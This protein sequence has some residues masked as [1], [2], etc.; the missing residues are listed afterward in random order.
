MFRISNISKETILTR[1]KTWGRKSSLAIIDQGIFS[2]A[3]F[4][5]A[6]LLA[7]WLLPNDYGAF[8]ISFSILMIFYQIYVS[9]LLDPITVLAPLQNLG[10]LKDYLA[11]QLKSHFIITILS[12]VILIVVAMFW[13][14]G[15]RIIQEMVVTIG[16]VLPVLLLPWYFRRVFY[17]LGDPGK[18]LIGSFFYALTL[19]VLTFIAYKI[20][21]L[22]SQSGILIM[23]GASILC[24]VYFLIAFRFWNFNWLSGIF[25][26]FLSQNWKIGKWL[27][28]SS[29][30]I[31]FAS[32]IQIWIANT[33]FGLASSATLRAFQ[34]LTQPM[35]LIITALTTLSIP[36]LT[37]DFSNNNFYSYHRKIIFLGLSLLFLALV[38]EIFLFTFHL[39]IE[40]FIYAGKFSK[41]TYLLPIWGIIPIILAYTSG[42]QAGFQAIK[43]PQALL[44][45]SIIWSVGSAILGIWLSLQLGLIGLVWS[46]VLG[47]LLFAI[48]L[49]LLYV[50]WIYIPY[51]KNKILENE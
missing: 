40:F 29:F 28:F 47:Y 5:L 39:Q 48:V 12:G 26:T 6:V 21:K 9:F 32:Q 15:N 49:S 14:R 37:I 17:I 7:R 16:S 3:N 25:L 24:S 22:N 23:A 10:I 30:F 20:E 42:F 51:I 2:G 13:M 46:A 19:I 1:L 35:L 41:E 45:A 18:A 38:F 44:I 43:K 34:V 31:A 36:T 4:L 50:I 27:I 8:S 33:Y 11:K